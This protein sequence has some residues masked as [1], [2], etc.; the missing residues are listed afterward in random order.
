MSRPFGPVVR[1]T[2]RQRRTDLPPPT[3][4]YEHYIASPE[5]A[6]KRGEFWKVNARTCV[7]CG[8]S[9][10]LHVHHHTYARL[11]QEDLADLVAVCATCH[12]TIHTIYREQRTQ[13]RNPSLTRVTEQVLGIE[14]GSPQVPKPAP[15]PPADPQAAAKEVHRIA[16]LHNAQRQYHLECKRRERE[17]QE[18]ALRT[19]QAEG[20]LPPGPAFKS[21]ALAGM[22]MP[23][24]HGFIPRHLRDVERLG[25]SSLRRT[26]DDTPTWLRSAPRSGRRP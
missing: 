1:S 7:G 3:N 13:R 25:G 10:N 26:S 19:L 21:R 17:A 23:T 11:Y 24:K 20:K 5:W 2:R 14:L 6:A 12:E 4:S 18:T 16:R 15:T 22:L 9:K 8:A